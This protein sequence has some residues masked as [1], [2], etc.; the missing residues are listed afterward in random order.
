M[1]HE[2]P[3]IEAIQEGVSRFN[4]GIHEIIHPAFDAYWQDHNIIVKVDLAGFSGKEVEINLLYNVLTITAKRKST[5]KVLS[6][7]EPEIKM[8]YAHRPE[9]LV[10]R[11]TLP[12]IPPKD[13]DDAKQPSIADKSTISNGVLTVKIINIP[14]LDIQ[15]PTG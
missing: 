7:A 1:G 15:N 10:A 6:D 5:E 4:R 11:I 13:D 12:F 9:T 3:L 8:I 14:K 2:N